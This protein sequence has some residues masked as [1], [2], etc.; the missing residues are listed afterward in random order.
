MQEQR[1]QEIFEILQGEKIVKI[2]DLADS[3]GVS[4]VTMRKDIAELE[5]MGLVIKYHG[6]VSLAKSGPIPY[7]DRQNE[8][9]ANK[10][11]IAKRAAELIRGCGSIMLDAG[12]TTMLIAEQ[13]QSF[14]PINIITNSLS[15]ASTLSRSNHN[16]TILGGILLNK[17]MCTVGP[18]TQEE[19]A[20]MEVEKLFIGCTGIRGAIGLTTGVATEAAVKRDMVKIA[21]EV[22]AVF[23]DTKFEQVGIEMFAKFTDIDKII[24]TRPK[25]RPASLNAIE[26]LDVQIIYANE[27]NCN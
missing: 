3:F 20:K 2:S 23:D 5:D 14:D 10:L 24:T 11:L 13:I 1:M 18:E 26:Q 22:I 8:N 7:S 4:Q 25:K 19:L 16:V 15:V 27:P 12:T 6:K 17:S 21:R 9:Y